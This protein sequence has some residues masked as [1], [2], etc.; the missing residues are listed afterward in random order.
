MTL[1]THI[2]KAALVKNPHKNVQR[3][4]GLF[5][6]KAARDYSL[7]LFNERRYKFQHR[8]GLLVIVKVFDD[9]FSPDR[10]V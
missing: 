7:A 9:I 10:P 4:R 1:I 3:V 2:G 8:E 6:H 5:E